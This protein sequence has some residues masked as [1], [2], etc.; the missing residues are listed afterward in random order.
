MLSVYIGEG[1][2]EKCA[3]H[4]EQKVG[5][6]VMVPTSWGN[7]FHCLRPAL[8]T[9]L[10]PAQPSFPLMVERGYCDLPV[11]GLGPPACWGGIPDS[12]DDSRSSGFISVED[13]GLCLAKSEGH[14]CLS[15]LH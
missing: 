4:L 13:K 5:R 9:A 15:S 11:M 7:L 2:L 8:G 1:R 12:S 6:F 14:Y 3:G 10:S